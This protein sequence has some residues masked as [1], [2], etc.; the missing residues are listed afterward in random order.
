MV[1][2]AQR[3]KRP[4]PAPNFFSVYAQ[5]RTYTGP[6]QGQDP[7]TRKLARRCKLRRDERP[8]ESQSLATGGEWELGKRANPCWRGSKKGNLKTSEVLPVYMNKYIFVGELTL[9][10]LRWGGSESRMSGG[11]WWLEWLEVDQVTTEARVRVGRGLHTDKTV[12]QHNTCLCRESSP[13]PVTCGPLESLC[14]RCSP[15]AGSSHTPST[16]TSK[17]S[18]IPENSSAIRADR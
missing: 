1:E 12:T 17:S 14:G 8:R 16:L 13:Q 4:I 15:S 6:T 5:W 9:K 10:K 3:A 11:L 7:G 18:W 2:Q